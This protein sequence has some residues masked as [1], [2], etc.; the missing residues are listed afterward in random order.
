MVDIYDEFPGTF[1][2]ATELTGKRL[3]VTIAGVEKTEM[4]DG[5][6]KPVLHFK[7]DARGLV[8]NVENRA[9]LVDRFGRETDGWVGK[10]VILITRPVQGP[11]G[12]C[13][14]IRFADASVG[15]QIDDE[16][17]AP[18]KRKRSFTK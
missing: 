9:T 7:E 12:P 4:N 18:P 13:Q 6:F 15:E 3:P 14:G 8:L 10:N 16:L 17:P 2:R 11:N 5:R 1:F